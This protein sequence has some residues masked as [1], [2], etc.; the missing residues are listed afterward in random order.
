[1]TRGGRACASIFLVVLAT[2]GL[3]AVGT[4]SLEACPAPHLTVSPATVQPSQKITIA[5]TG[6]VCTTSG[7]PAPEAPIV[8]LDLK[9]VQGAVARQVG[10]VDTGG[11]F[12]V[13]T[14]IP[15]TARSGSARIE[16]IGTA[17]AAIASIHVAGALAHTGGDP[18]SDLLFFAALLV[19]AGML[20]RAWANAPF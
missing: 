3:L 8:H 19:I 11:T 5:G 6:F 7:S 17:V 10:A 9:F 4:T 12:T 13:S 20:V 1:M 16:A 14:T 15:A 18:T 2:A